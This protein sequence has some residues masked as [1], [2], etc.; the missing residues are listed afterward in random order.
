VVADE[1]NG[2]PDDARRQLEAAGAPA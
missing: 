1:R 2:A